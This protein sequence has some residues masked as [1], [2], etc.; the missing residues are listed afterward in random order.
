MIFVQIFLIVVQHCLTFLL[1]ECE[2]AVTFSQEGTG[3][4]KLIDQSTCW[5]WKELKQWKPS[6]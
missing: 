3:Y 5:K 6:L 1:K 4:L 2:F